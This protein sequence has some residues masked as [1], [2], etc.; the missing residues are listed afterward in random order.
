MEKT[1]I[2]GLSVSDRRNQPDPLDCKA[3][4]WMA[5]KWERGLTSIGANQRF[6]LFH[7]CGIR[8]FYS[9]HG[10]TLMNEEKR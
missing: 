9:N 2:P 10:L 5:R 8:G 7:F 4:R 3:K 6:R 1:I